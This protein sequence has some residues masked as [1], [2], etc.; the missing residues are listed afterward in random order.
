M[1]QQCL[2]YEIP[3]SVITESVTLLGSIGGSAGVGYILS[4]S[5]VR[6]LCVGLKAAITGIG[7]LVCGVVV[8][9]AGSIVGGVTLSMVGEDAGE[10]IDEMVE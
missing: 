3:K 5:V 10:L 8:V 1:F 9:R 7:N 6:G 4:G 2:L